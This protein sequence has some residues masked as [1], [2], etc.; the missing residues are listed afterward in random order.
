MSPGRL[1]S[2]TRCLEARAG[3][4]EPAH[5]PSRRVP[6]EGPASEGCK[7]GCPW[8]V[9]AVVGGPPQ[10]RRRTRRP[11]APSLTAGPDPRSR[12]HRPRGG[13]P[14]QAR[15]AS[16]TGGSAGVSCGAAG[17]EGR[18]AR[19]LLSRRVR[20]ARGPG[21]EPAGRRSRV[22]PTSCAARACW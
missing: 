22:G 15:A 14:D 21:G 10:T 2:G 5:G 13:V 1:P 12:S 4:A 8:G 18:V 17:P 6:E 19:S 20:R 11:H 7:G 16:G 9:R 3:S